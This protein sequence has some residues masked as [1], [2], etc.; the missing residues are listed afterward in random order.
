MIRRLLR[1]PVLLV[2]PLALLV[3]ACTERLDTAI[4]CPVLCPGQQLDIVDTIIDPAVV[5]DT[6]LQTFPLLGFENS[7]LVASRGDTLDTRAIIRFDSLPRTF[8]PPADTARPVT[9]VDSATLS[10]RLAKTRIKVP[11]TFY[12]DAFDVG[13]TTLV[14]SLPTTLLP[15]FTLSRRLGSLQVDSATF[16]DSSTV[17]IV[18][19]S[20]RVRRIIST[21]GAVLRIGLQLRSTES[22]AFLVTSSEDATNGPVLRYRVSADT[23]VA[24]VTV[25]PSSLTPRVPVNVNGDLI[26]YLLVADAPDI[27]RAGRFSV[28][29]FPG[30]RSYLRFNLP[31]WLTD[32]AAV[33][34]AQLEFVQDPVRGLDERDSLTVRAQVVLAGNGTTDLNRAARLLAPAGFFVGDF[35]RVAPADSGIVRLEINALIRL[36]RA[37]T[38]VQNIPSALILR[39]ELEGSSGL[40]ANFFGLS[41]ASGLRPRLRVS[42]VPNIRFGQP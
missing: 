10:I 21:P 6:T 32:S 11:R 22:G 38:G 17:K 16:I 40:G 3:G 31:R 39:S 42:Y 30:R 29:G 25:R 41:A 37:N 14:D 7:L 33:L 5:L 19:D 18:L 36:W 26:D 34:R 28:G 20:A 27:R 4:A 2:F 35:V 12:V 24:A 1:A 13:D 15:F 23:L 8:A 9:F